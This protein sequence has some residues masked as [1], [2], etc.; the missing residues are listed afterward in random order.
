MV[1]RCLLLAVACMASA[2]AAT[3]SAL[4]I[5]ASDGTQLPATLLRPEGTGPFPAVVIVHDC[6]GL[7][8][9]S[10]GA[11]MRWARELVAQ[12]Y[13]ALVPDSFTPRGFPDGV[14]TVPGAE[15][16]AVNG[17]VRARD[18]HAA[19]AALQ[20]LPEVDGRHVGL[21]GGS[22]GG[23]TT[24]AAM[25]RPE[26]VREPGRR[27]EFAAAIALYPICGS[28]LGEWNIRREKGNV[29]PIVEYMGVYKPVA[30]VLILIGA[31]DDW[32]P[33]EACQKLVEASRAAGF[34]VDIKV[35][36][37]ALHSFD[38]NAPVRYVPQRNNANSRDGRGATTGGNAD[39]WADARKQVAEFFRA[40][41]KE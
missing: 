19:L 32:T 17:I 21:M 16:R 8:P 3:E 20:A 37:D 38:S 28:R 40:H 12:G 33:A 7:G 23:W 27:G 34:A 35:Y 9:R 11:P 4:T 25:V 24:L 30:P 22:H 5:P 39:A 18:A 15:S 2:F 31:K 1:F 26:D 14:C 10:S 6:S 41:L 36:P 29:G 13:V